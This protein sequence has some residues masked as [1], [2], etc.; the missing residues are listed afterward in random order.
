MEPHSLQ[1]TSHPAAYT[2]QPYTPDAALAVL[3]LARTALGQTPATPMTADFWRW[4][5]E[6]NPFGPS[7]GLVAWDGPDATPIGVRLFLRWM[8][9]TPDGSRLPAVRAV[10]TATHPAHR[11]R[12]IFSR[13][14]RQ[15]LEELARDGVALVF[16]TPNG[17]S[18]PG[19]L[20]LGWRLVA[21]WP[22]YLRPLRPGRMLARRLRPYRG[23][24]A[25]FDAYFGPGILP[26]E[27]FRARFGAELPAL[28]ATWEQARPR[29]GLR[30]PR[31]LA[32]LDWRYGGH[33]HVPYGVVPLVGEGRPEA[34]LGFA[35]LR[36]NVRFGWQEVVWTE[37]CLAEP[38]PELGKRLLRTLTRQVR[39]D[40]LIAHFARGSWEQRLLARWGFWPL[41]RRG[42]TFV[43]RP[44]QPEFEYAI[45]PDA[46][47]L[48]LGDL[49]LF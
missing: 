20:K 43:V 24:P 32:Y 38:S 13:L 23:T 45:R 46:W 25:A 41:P 4:K 35:V 17:Q 5:H 19:Y 36:P 47:D 29:R 28:L 6:V 48:T 14:T 30:T 8:W 37:L 7:Y 12:G 42:L 44:L 34:L 26:W 11:R 16:N 15:A 21:H 33:P 31:T 18:L 3:E 27:A 10:D 2:V 1:A 22:L 49:E 40:Y 9:Q 39:G